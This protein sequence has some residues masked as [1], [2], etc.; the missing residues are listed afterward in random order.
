MSICFFATCRK[1]S[2]LHHQKSETQ[3]MKKK[4]VRFLTGFIFLK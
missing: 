2:Y 1:L 4:P 3:M